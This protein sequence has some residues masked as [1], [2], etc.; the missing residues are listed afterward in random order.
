[1]SYLSLG[2][3]REFGV[4]F[5]LV[6]VDIAPLQGATPYMDPLGVVAGCVRKLDSSQPGHLLLNGSEMQQKLKYEID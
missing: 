4:R 5:V 6:S 2:I 3:V 1:M